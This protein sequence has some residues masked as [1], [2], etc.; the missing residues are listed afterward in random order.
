MRVFANMA[1]V[2]MHRLDGPVGL[3]ASQGAMV[4][5]EWT[6]ATPGTFDATLGSVA[7]VLTSTN[8][9]PPLAALKGTAS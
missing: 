1:D 9:M 7:N 5:A 2:E 4:F 6:V 8:G 3:A